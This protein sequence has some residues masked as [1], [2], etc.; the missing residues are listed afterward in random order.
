MRTIPDT[1]ISIIIP[2]FRAIAHIDT[3]SDSINFQTLQPSEVIILNN[4]PDI[5]ILPSDFNLSVPTFVINTPPKNVVLA[6]LIGL[7]SSSSKYIAFLD[8]DD[9]WYPEKLETQIAAILDSG[10]DWC[11]SL[12][13]ICDPNG[14]FLAT[15]PA[16][17]TSTRPIKILLGKATVPMSS[18]LIRR[19]LLISLRSPDIFYALF[20]STLNICDHGDLLYRLFR[21]SS[22]VIIDQPLCVYTLGSGLSV[23]SNQ[24][25]SVF[26]VCLLTYFL[27]SIR[28]R[29]FDLCDFPLIFIHF[30]RTVISRFFRLITRC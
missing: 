22:G 3:L 8:A 24:S 7:H 1:S 10:L 11:G 19:S 28:L 2:F 13:N 14:N 9:Q 4:D 30:T 12:A 17:T 15:T 21:A 27:S 18:L 20:P 23:S 16:V 6:R 29:S 5:I 25:I 26:R